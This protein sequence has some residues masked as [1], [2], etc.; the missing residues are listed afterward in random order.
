M[1]NWAG[2]EIYKMA[3]AA[4]RVAIDL[5]TILKLYRHV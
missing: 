5:L 4:S 1:L 2:Q 3:P